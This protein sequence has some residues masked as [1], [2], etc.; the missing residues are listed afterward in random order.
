MEGWSP[1]KP[2]SHLAITVN[3]H[4][5]EQN[6]DCDDGD[7]DND[8]GGGYQVCQGGAVRQLKPEKKSL[9]LKTIIAIIIDIMKI[10]KKK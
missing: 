2:G 7:D 1:R 5:D 4:D 10:I 9:P 8:D 3:D 6:S